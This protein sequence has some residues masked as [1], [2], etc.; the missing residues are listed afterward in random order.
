[1]QPASVP[2]ASFGADFD[3]GGG[4]PRMRMGPAIAV[5]VWQYPLRLAHWGLVLSIAALALTGYYIH[6]PYIVAQAQYPFLM[7]WIRF[8]HESF[9][10]LFIALFLL[11]M[12]LFVAGDRWVR[13]GAMAPL[14]GAKWK[15]MLEVMKFYAFI[16]PTPVSKVGHN[17]MAA[18]SYLGIYTMAL[19]EIVS[20]LVMFNWL[21]HSPILTPLVGWIPRV[22]GIQNI[23]LLHFCLMFVFIA[24]GILHVHLCL[25]VS[26]AEKRGLLDSIFTGYKIIPVNELEEDDRAAIETSSGKG[27][28]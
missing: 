24:F 15:E 28:R 10:M 26:S 16:R 1:M 3:A 8:T 2:R 19:L 6:N 12:Y 4:H 18:L 17:P 13:F 23:R 11:R 25:I 20:G 22:I 9:G 5:Y 7:G 21:R 27:V 14:S